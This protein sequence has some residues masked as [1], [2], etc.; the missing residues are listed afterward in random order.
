M[1]PS[2]HTARDGAC[3]APASSGDRL[4]YACGT[5]TGGHYNSDLAYPG[6]L[7]CVGDTKHLQFN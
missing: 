7:A 6:D 3:H 5:P 1:I 2:I 4:E